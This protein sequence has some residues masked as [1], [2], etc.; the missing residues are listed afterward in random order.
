MELFAQA[1]FQVCFAWAL[2]ENLSGQQFVKY[3]TFKK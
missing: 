1:P 3:K 2:S